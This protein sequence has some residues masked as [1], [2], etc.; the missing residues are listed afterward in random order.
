MPPARTLKQ[1][2][3]G[4]T[5]VVTLSGWPGFLHLAAA[6]V[7][8]PPHLPP[9]GAQV[10]PPEI[11]WARVPTLDS[12]NLSAHSALVVHLPDG[13]LVG[14]LNPDTQLPLASLTKV[15][16]SVVSMEVNSKLDR[17][18]TITGDDNTGALTPYIAAGDSISYLAVKDGETMRF[19]DVLSAALV[20]SANNAAA[21]LARLTGLTP[22]DFVARMNLRAQVLGMLGTTF[23]EPTGL[24]PANTS[25]AFDYAILAR[26]A[27][28]NKTLRTVSGQTD[29][30]FT[31][32]S[33]K[34]HHLRNTNSLVKNPPAGVKVTASKT[35][36]LHEAGYN[37]AIT[38]RV[39]SGQQYLLVLLHAPTL[40][41]RTADTLKIINW[42]EAKS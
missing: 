3:L 7:P 12:L 13:Q 36:F 19:G 31:D 40:V 23:T 20:A 16:T 24:D 4:L 25:T 2:A 38:F 14:A 11:D 21:A 22:A 9:L 6:E 10:I 26:Y 32:A 37:E 42:L 39:P 34:R 33:G 18:V 28:A 35:G 15:M 41:A 17:L 27:W 30:W 5:L 1:L 29:F 8:P